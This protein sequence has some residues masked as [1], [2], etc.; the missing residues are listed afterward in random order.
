[1]LAIDF[2]YHLG[3]ILYNYHDWLTNNGWPDIILSRLITDYPSVYQRAVYDYISVLKGVPPKYQ[4]ELV[5]HSDIEG[6]KE[7]HEQRI[8]TMQ[9][10]QLYDNNRAYFAS[11]ALPTLIERFLINFTQHNLVDNMLKQII[12]KEQKGELSISDSDLKF[13]NE[14]LYSQDYISGSQESAMKK[15]LALFKSAGLVSDNETGNIVLGMNNRSPLTLGQF[16][17]NNY[18]KQHIKPAYYNVMEMLFS[19]NSVNLRNTIMHGSSVMFDP[20]AVC[21]AAVMLQLFWAIID[22]T[23]FQ[24]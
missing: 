4:F 9:R 24:N 14:V 6:V 16:L 2:D 1:M 23:I 8:N 11:Y 19:T 20:Y 13:A 18:A 12:D 22:R 3:G 10:D 17:K 15:C 7:E 21:F 5:F